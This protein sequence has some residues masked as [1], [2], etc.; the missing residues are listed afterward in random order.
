MQR[1]LPTPVIGALAGLGV[2][3]TALTL[4][5]GT[6]KSI[7]TDSA[8]APVSL[9][10][11]PK[12]TPTTVPTPTPVAVAD[13]A[14]PPAPR[15]GPGCSL[16]ASDSSGRGGNT[17]DITVT[18]TSESVAAAVVEAIPTT[19]WGGA[20]AALFADG[21]LRVSAPPTFRTD[22]YGVA[23]AWFRSNPDVTDVVRT[24]KPA[25]GLLVCL[26]ELAD[27]SRLPEVLRDFV[28]AGS[29]AG[30]KYSL[31]GSSAEVWLTRS[32]TLEPNW[33]ALQ[34]ALAALGTVVGS[35]RFDAWT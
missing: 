14:P 28:N 24:E 12:A 32:A 10:V 5:L 1:M 30:Y 6:P 13:P 7:S 27:P 19:P 20:L 26:T 25:V 8:N 33:D 23:E 34:A 18:L 17:A 29:A 16:A 4:S 35:Q 2:L 31:T 3:T 11:K 21:A 15:T 22:E 9:A